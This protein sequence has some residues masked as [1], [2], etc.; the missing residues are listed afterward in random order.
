M[1]NTCGQNMWSGQQF[2]WTM[3]NRLDRLVFVRVFVCLPA[4]LS[5]AIFPRVYVWGCTS[6]CLCALMHV[7]MQHAARRLGCIHWR[8]VRHVAGTG[9]FLEQP[10][11]SVTL[12]RWCVCLNTS[13]CQLSSACRG[14]GVYNSS[15]L[16]LGLTRFPFAPGP[17]NQARY[18]T[19]R[20]TS[21]TRLRL[22]HPALAFVQ[23]LNLLLV[24]LKN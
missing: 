20:R 9:R 6:F 7:R 16:L 1:V 21:S 23:K 5:V 24:L 3:T 18:G 17:A 11:L 15:L 22:G 13:V 12:D 19:R 4:C 14:T 2:Y 10:H 8:Q